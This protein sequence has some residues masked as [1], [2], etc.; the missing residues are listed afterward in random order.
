MVYLFYGVLV[1]VSVMD[2]KKK[3]I[4]DSLLAVGYLMV[5]V[6]KPDCSGKMILLSAVLLYTLFECAKGRM[7][8][9][10]VKLGILLISY[11]G[12]FLLLELLFLA[13]VLMIVV[14]G[15]LLYKK[16]I[17]MRTEIPFAPFLCGACLIL[18]AILH[19]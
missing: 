8:F 11:L 2:L 5:L 19:F 9:G 1:M 15:P 4:P 10:D 3:I 6:A 17:S 12:S 13:C 7:G 16:R 18:D 14:T